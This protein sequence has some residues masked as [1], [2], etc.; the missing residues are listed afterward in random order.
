VELLSLPR[1]VASNHSDEEARSDDA[2]SHD[3]DIASEPDDH[4]EMANADD[5]NSGDAA[6]V[7]ENDCEDKRG[8]RTSPQ[9]CWP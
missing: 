7:E 8:E 6:S 1:G 2:V 4:A 5:H 3:A 9:K